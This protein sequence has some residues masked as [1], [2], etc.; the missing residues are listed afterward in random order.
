MILKKIK[1]IEE[2]LTK[3]E[4]KVERNHKDFWKYLSELSKKIKKK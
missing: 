3:I 4:E 2:R 1:K